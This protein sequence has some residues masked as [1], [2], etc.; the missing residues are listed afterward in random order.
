MAALRVDLLANYIV[1][2]FR[3][4]IIVS[5]SHSKI[6]F[7]F[8]WRNY[9]CNSNT[10]LWNCSQ[11]MLSEFMLNSLAS[12]NGFFKEYT[13]GKV[14]GSFPNEELDFFNLLNTFSR[15]L[16]WRWTNLQQKWV[17]RVFLFVKRSQSVSVAASLSSAS[18]FSR[19]TT[20]STSHDSEE[21]HSLL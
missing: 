14:M 13:S 8:H 20:S 7:T 1:V 19:K 5:H 9:L 12:Y 15:N 2:L 17:L 21:L 3:L 16:A 11:E 18:R 6:M 10:Q 4:R